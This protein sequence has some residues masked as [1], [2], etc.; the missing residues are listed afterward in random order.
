MRAERKKKLFERKYQLILF[1]C[2]CR[3]S[4][5]CALYTMYPV[6]IYRHQICS[7]RSY[8][9][10]FLPRKH[11]HARSVFLF[12]S[13]VI[14]WKCDRYHVPIK[15]ENNQK[16]ATPNNGHDHF[17]QMYRL[18]WWYVV[19]LYCLNVAVIVKTFIQWALD[20]CVY[21]FSESNTTKWHCCRWRLCRKIR[22]KNPYNECIECICGNAWQR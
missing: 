16:F 14:Y 1:L 11:T 7:A 5:K 18:L 22:R 15:S 20:A 17:Q 2:V 21:H 19:Y 13:F 12:R 6:Y 3:R 4:M 8:S 9:R 10:F